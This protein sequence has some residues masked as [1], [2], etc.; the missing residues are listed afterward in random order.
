MSSESKPQNLLEIIGGTELLF[1]RDV[2]SLT[3]E[4]TV[5]AWSVIDLLEKIAKDRKES[6]REALL[7]LAGEGEPSEKGS[8]SVEVDGTRIIAEARTPEFPDEKKLKEIMK[9]K[10]LSMDL[11]FDQ[12]TSYQLNPIKLDYLIDQ[13]KITKEEVDSCR[14]TTYALKVQ[15]DRETKDRLNEIKSNLKGK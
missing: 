7:Q 8:Y 14:K 15:P 13:G 2:K 3:K 5:I 11:C 1:S 9:S 12:V 6:F 10:K 4:Q